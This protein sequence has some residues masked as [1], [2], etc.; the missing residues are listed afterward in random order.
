MQAT[1]KKC[2]DCLSDIPT[3]ARKCSHCGSLQTK[4][5]NTATSVLY[6]SILLLFLFWIGAAIYNAA[7]ETR[8]VFDA[9]NNV[10]RNNQETVANDFER[11]YYDVVRAGGSAVD[12]CVRAGLVAE[13]YLQ[14]GNTA[15]YQEWQN[16]RRIDCTAAGVAF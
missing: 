14:S 3:E 5:R 10:Y 11:Q 1:I 6:G 7:N 4:P 2:I 13:G 8:T 16:Q 9:P 12:K 15:K